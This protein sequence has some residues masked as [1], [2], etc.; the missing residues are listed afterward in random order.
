M[1]YKPLAIF[2]VEFISAT[3]SQTV[4]LKGLKSMHKIIH[5]FLDQ[6]KREE[7]GATVTDMGWYGLISLSP[8]PG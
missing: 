1:E 6:R 7:D 5:D 4:T 8:Y 3:A 2:A